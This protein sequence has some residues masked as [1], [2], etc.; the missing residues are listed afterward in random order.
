MDTISG[1]VAHDRLNQ[2]AAR[3]DP[4]LVRAAAL[5]ELDELFRN[6]AAPEHPLEGRWSGRLLTMSVTRPTDAAFRAIARIYMP[7]LGKS[8]D[9]STST[10]I[11]IWKPSV[12]GPMRLLWR[13]YVPE[14]ELADRIEAFPFRTRQ[15]PGEV[16]PDTQVLKI[17][18]DIEENPQFLVRRVLDELVQIDDN[19]YLG[20]ILFHWRASWR[21]IGFFSLER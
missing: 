1:S 9:P 6:S 13:N 21:P 20:K 5:A 2:V 15:G 19:L 12:R 18:Y 7:W 10:G 14:R 11:N 17:D 8:F 16:D 4:R 3:L